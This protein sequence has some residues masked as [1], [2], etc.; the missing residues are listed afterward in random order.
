MHVEDA[1]ETRQLQRPDHAPIVGDEHELSACRTQLASDVD[2]KRQRR[3]LEKRDAGQIDE[4]VSTATVED[5]RQL[6]PERRDGVHVELAADGDDV[7]VVAE[8]GGAH[9]DVEKRHHGHH[10]AVP[11]VVQPRFCESSLT[12]R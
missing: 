7:T 8:A 12:L 9:A 1:V 5:V 10:T 3:R 6:F 4:D 11:M 2:K